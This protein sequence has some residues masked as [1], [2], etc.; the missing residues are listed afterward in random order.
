MI[1]AHRNAAFLTLQGMDENDWRNAQEMWDR[2]R[3]SRSRVFES[4]AKAAV[5]MGI[6]ES[7]YRQYERGPESSRFA[8][9]D[10][11]YA[12]TFAKKFKVNW[13]WLLTGVGE[14]FSTV[15]DGQAELI[16]LYGKLEAP[17]RSLLLDLARNLAGTSANVV[18]VDL[19]PKRATVTRSTKSRA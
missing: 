6:P 18:Q 11:E 5:S 15:D 12:K 19:L 7:T 1:G 10:E 13:V 4:A 8:V 3:W 2:V 16:N 14:P 9:L 17:Q